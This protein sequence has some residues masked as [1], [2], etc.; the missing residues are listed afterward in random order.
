[1]VL[2]YLSNACG[3]ERIKETLQVTEYSWLWNKAS[4]KQ[5]I[6]SSVKVEIE[7]NV[8]VDLEVEDEYIIDLLDS[9]K[10]GHEHV[11]GSNEC[12]SDCYCD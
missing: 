2:S 6:S 9:L 11:V 10:C 1:M 3:G 5:L 8:E 4:I 12:C 7:P